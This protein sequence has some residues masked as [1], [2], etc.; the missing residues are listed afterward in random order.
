MSSGV[1]AYGATHP[2]QVKHMP[3]ELACTLQNHT[4]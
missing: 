1:A 4:L 3:N 2:E